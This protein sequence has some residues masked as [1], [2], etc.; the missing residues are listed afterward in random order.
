M[1]GGCAYSNPVSPTYLKAHRS[2]VRIS[3][4]GGG[5][6]DT[7]PAL[8]ATAGS[9]ASSMQRLSRRMSSPNRPHAAQ[10]S[11]RS[12][13]ESIYH[14]SSSSGRRR[15]TKQYQCCFMSA[16]RN[17][18]VPLKFFPCLIPR[19]QAAG[20]LSGFKVHPVPAY[21]AFFHSVHGCVDF[22]M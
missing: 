8:E 20:R 9:Y 22:G 18:L 1:A 4:V 2:A 11:R 7:V 19:V 10:E 16:N 17:T 5:H 21:L 15:R 6:P 13:S 3:A 14:A 12:R